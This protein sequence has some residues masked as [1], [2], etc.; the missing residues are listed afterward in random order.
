MSGFYCKNPPEDLKPL[1]HELEDEYEISSSS[2]KIR[3]DFI[4]TDTPGRLEVIQHVFNIEII[5]SSKVSAARGLMIALSGLSCRE[6]C[7]FELSGVMID[8]SRNAV[9]TLP[10]LKR[11][12]RRLASFGCNELMLYTES[13]YKLPGEPYF[14]YMCGAYTQAEIKELDDYAYQFGVE[15]IGCIQVLG[16]ME[17]LLKWFI[18]Y[19]EIRDTAKVLMA[20]EPG[21]YSLIAKMLDFWSGALRSRKIHI[22]MDETFGVGRGAFLDRHGYECEFDIFN[23]HLAKVSEMCSARKLQPMIWSDMYFRLANENQDYYASNAMA[24]QA[25]IDAIPHNVQLVYWDY[26]HEDVSFYREFIQRHKRMGKLPVMA[27]GLWTWMKFWFDPEHTDLTLTPCLQACKQEGISNFL[28]TM[29]GDDGNFCDIDSALAGLCRASELIWNDNVEPE[30]VDKIFRTVM[31]QDYR[32]YLVPGKLDYLTHCG[33]K[34]VRYTASV[35]LW[36]D[37]LQ[38]LAT[39]NYRIMNPEADSVFVPYYQKL[40]EELSILAAENHG[41]EGDFAFAAAIAQA[42]AGKVR[43]RIDLEQAYRNRDDQEL[44]RVAETIPT[45][46]HAYEE[47]A[48]AMRKMWLRN[49]KPFGLEIQQIRMAGTIAR[50]EETRLRLLELLD[51]VIDSIPELDEILESNTECG[52]GG[53]TYWSSSA[54]LF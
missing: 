38:A 20:D 22:G 2:G 14:G 1:L 23:R 34:P 17:R 24:P 44:R 8:C 9:I 40:A 29:W 3:L 18:P 19:R 50:L 35:L 12:I 45:I 30:K 54:A 48:S 31:K 42:L 46:K 39:R 47:A 15:I 32:K 53:Y 13:T 36:D 33:E 10:S 51:G 5:Y 52:W 6:N 27:S 7:T 21:T 16:H 28:M 26:Y 4:P 37:P 41:N 11:W 25:V 43:L 49:Y